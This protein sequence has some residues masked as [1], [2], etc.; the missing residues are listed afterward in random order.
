[1]RQ[2]TR[3]VAYTPRKKRAQHR[4]NYE[5]DVSHAKSWLCVVYAAAVLL[6]LLI[7]HQQQVSTAATFSVG[8]H[9]VFHTH[10][11]RTLVCPSPSLSLPTPLPHEKVHKFSRS[12]RENYD[13]CTMYI[14][15]L[16]DKIHGFPSFFC[17]PSSFRLKIDDFF[18]YWTFF[19]RTL[20]IAVTLA[21]VFLKSPI[22][23]TTFFFFNFLCLM[24]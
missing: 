3:I 15:R 4:E 24:F 13:R 12:P 5:I 7:V 11:H 1:M 20:I 23:W 22:R 16:N 19:I 14:F 6:Y 2:K 18:S 10:A 17:L 21:I 8:I 9:S